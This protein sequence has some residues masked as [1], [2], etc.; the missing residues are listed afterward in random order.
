VDKF[1]PKDWKS[2]LSKKFILIVVPSTGIAAGTIVLVANHGSIW[3][4]LI[5]LPIV[6]VF[7]VTAKPEEELE[8]FE[9]PPLNNSDDSPGPWFGYP[10]MVVLAGFTVFIPV[11]VASF[12]T[13]DG[14]S[15]PG[16]AQPFWT[17]NIVYIPTSSVAVGLLG[18]YSLLMNRINKRVQNGMLEAEAIAWL[19]ESSQDPDPSLFE[20]AGS[21]AT[22]PP[23]KAL[24][25]SE[26]IISLLP[27]MI[28]SRLGTTPGEHDNDSEL[29]KLLS[30]LE[31]SSNFNN[32]KA[33]RFINQKLKNTAAIK[34]PKLPSA[35]LKQL[36][37]LSKNEGSHLGV[38]AKKILSREWEWEENEGS[39]LQSSVEEFVV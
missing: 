19:L 32:T 23:R 10:Q 22:T 36:Q 3:Q 17:K 30:F 33:N 34:H 5:L 2:S 8:S 11:A 1:F 18:L 20:K 7:A 27:H 6:G 25:L 39:G 38:T 16:K 28:A 4:L 21:V 35:L 24:L 13:R 15:D 31:C 14:A 37:V 29:R 12:F 26:T 9:T